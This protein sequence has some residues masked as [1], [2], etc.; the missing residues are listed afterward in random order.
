MQL[1]EYLML[2]RTTNADICQGFSDEA[3]EALEAAISEYVAEHEAELSF[4]EHNDE[5][6]AAL[7]AQLSERSDLD[8]DLH[9]LPGDH[10]YE[11]RL[12]IAGTRRRVV[13]YANAA[14]AYQGLQQAIEETAP[15]LKRLNAN[16]P[17]RCTTRSKSPARSA[18][19]SW[20]MCSSS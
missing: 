19:R 3:E 11:L 10:G 7:V 15:V 14:Y 8:Y 16:I 2:D 6:L 20:V 1:D 5:Q 17:R 4:D 18:K 9:E 12:V 13:A